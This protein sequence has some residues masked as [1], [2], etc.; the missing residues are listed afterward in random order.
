MKK[1]SIANIQIEDFLSKVDIQSHVQN[2]LPYDKEKIYKTLFIFNKINN[3]IML[4]KRL[5]RRV[6]R[7]Y[8][9][10]LAS[11]FNWPYSFAENSKS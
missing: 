10:R 6:S 11:G 7:V 9:E 4:L 3:I 1:I 2:L 5:D 8:R